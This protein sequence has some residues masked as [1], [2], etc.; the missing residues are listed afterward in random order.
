MSKIGKKPIEIPNNVKVEIQ[1]Q[2]VL[3]EGPKGKLEKEFPSE[4]KIEMKEGKI[5]LSPKIEE[6]KLKGKLK[7]IK[8]L[9][10]LTRQLIFNM[11]EG[12]TKGFEK[13]L[14]IQGLGYRANMEGDTLVLQVGF[15]HPV[16]VT[17]PKEIKVTVEKNIIS[18][19]GID[20]ELVGQIA[21]KI[22]NVKPAEP[23]KE[24]GIKYL[25]ERIK[26]KV[27]KKAK[28]AK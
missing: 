3:V 1:G 16:K 15:S 7:K 2:R 23:Y 19:S 13:K 24:K 22:R 27:A 14:V 25:G 10:G 8:A 4:I 5:F 9:W 26:R 21:A 6:K 17:F 28:M 12:V 18:V 20:K 11:I